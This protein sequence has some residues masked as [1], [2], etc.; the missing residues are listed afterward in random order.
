LKIISNEI[1]STFV[2]S[3]YEYNRLLYSLFLLMKY[4]YSTVTFAFIYLYYFRFQRINEQIEKLCEYIIDNYKHKSIEAENEF[5]LIN[6]NITSETKKIN[7][8][9]KKFTKLEK[10]RVKQQFDHCQKVK[11]LTGN[12]E[13]RRIELYSQMKELCKI[14]ILIFVINF[15][16]SK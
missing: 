7:E 4:F 8:D 2:N 3:L 16:K 10:L 14:Q 5:V 1:S 15:D 11:H 12:F 9:K 6:I 13:S